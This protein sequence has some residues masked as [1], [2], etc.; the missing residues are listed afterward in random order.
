MYYNTLKKKKRLPMNLNSGEKKIETENLH[1][2]L[3]LQKKC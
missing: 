1:P 3:G 2:P